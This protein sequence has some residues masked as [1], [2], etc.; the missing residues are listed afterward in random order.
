M[1]QF[2]KIITKCRFCL[3]HEIGNREFVE[4]MLLRFCQ[5]KFYFF[6]ITIIFRSKYFF[7]KTNGFNNYML[8]G[9]AWDETGRFRNRRSTE[10]LESSASA[11]AI[12]NK[13]DIEAR[14]RILTLS[15]LSRYRKTKSAS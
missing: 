3:A 13:L 4:V 12:S 7:H 6:P 5:A 9:V 11:V 2:K 10:V 8:F 15:C 1:Y 14:M